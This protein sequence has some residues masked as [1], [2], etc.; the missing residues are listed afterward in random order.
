MAFESYNGEICL[1]A[2]EETVEH[3]FWHCPFAQ[4]CS[5]ILGLE[6][7]LDGGT[8]ENVLAIKDQ[9][10]SQFFMVVIILMSWTIWRARNE[11]IFNNNQVGIL[12]CRAFFFREV[13]LVSLRVKASL[14]SAFEQW[15]Q[16]LELIG[17]SGSFSLPLFGSLSMFA[18]LTGWLAGW[19]G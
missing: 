11:L 14:S 8:F 2:L 3:L 16:L 6:T 10:Q 1:Q 18:R 13:K 12:D 7:I 15:S 4:H 5:G 17:A 9:L 19:L